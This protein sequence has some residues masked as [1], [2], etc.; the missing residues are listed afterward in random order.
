M[1]EYTF[2]GDPPLTL[3][4]D[5][6]LPGSNESNTISGSNYTDNFIDGY[7]GDDTLLGG[8]WSD[9]I[10]GSDVNS[11][12]DDMDFLTGGLGFDTFVIGNW[13]G[14]F[15]DDYSGWA[16]INDFFD[17]RE[18]IVLNGTKDNVNFTIIDSLYGQES[19]PDLEISVG[20][21]TQAVLVDKGTADWV[22]NF[23][24]DLGG[25]ND[26]GYVYLST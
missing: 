19:I 5:Q 3:E 7:D 21:L 14:N 24:G 2:S 9:I 13:A 18:T 6:Y 26:L 20:G 15:Y 22:T 8:N 25:A 1:A 11:G 12:G 16:V 10:V 4:Y 17:H 23:S